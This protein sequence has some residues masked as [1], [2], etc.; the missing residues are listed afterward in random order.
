MT[1]C[2]FSNHHRVSF[3]MQVVFSF[4]R[5]MLRFVFPAWC[6]LS[7][8]FHDGG[9]LFGVGFGSGSC[10]PCVY[11]FCVIVGVIV[12]VVVVVV[13][14]FACNHSTTYPHIFYITNKHSLFFAILQRL[15]FE[16]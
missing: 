12:G 3:F 10:R 8:I 15:R 2:I 13:V 16:I 1:F 6:A 14:I 9:S 5:G 4:C 11:F 7:Q